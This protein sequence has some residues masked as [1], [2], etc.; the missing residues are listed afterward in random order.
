MTLHEQKLRAKFPNAP[1]SFFRRQLAD[2]AT[3]AAGGKAHVVAGKRIRQESTPLMNGLETRFLNQYLQPRHPESRIVPQGMRVK[4]A[5]GAWFKV[6]FF[7]P[8]IQWAYEVKGPKVMH[9]QQ[10]RQLLAL[11]VAASAWPEI[12]WHLATYS[13]GW[14]VIQVLP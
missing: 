11:K 5:N 14:N 4:L 3:V 7:I 8:E 9:N 1:E 6:D 10:S 12:K 2:S 13:D